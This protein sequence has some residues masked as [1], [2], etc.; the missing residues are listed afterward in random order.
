LS[1]IL[2]YAGTGD[3]VAWMLAHPLL[4]LNPRLR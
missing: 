1:R 3:A 2:D 4:P